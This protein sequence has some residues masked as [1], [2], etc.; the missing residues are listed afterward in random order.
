[1]KK[2]LLLIP[3]VAMLAAC[4]TTDV[5][6]KR[7]EV[8]QRA[9]REDREAILK[10]TPD[11]YKKLPISNSAIFAAGQ[12]Q[13]DTQEMAIVDAMTKAKAKVC[14][15]ADGEVSSQ[16][17]DFATGSTKTSRIE[18]ATR[19]NCNNVSIAGIE[20]GETKGDNPKVIAS[21]TGYIAFVLMALPTGD[22]NVQRKYL[23]NRKREASEAKRS[24]EAFQE[25]PAVKTN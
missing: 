21:N 24:T 9:D 13:A 6:Q 4:G 7:A 1:M 23:D 2:T 18:R 25:L 11:W 3:I 5:Y 10:Q 19:T 17:K 22:A 20:Y 14:Y 8:I 16:T 15:S 12:G